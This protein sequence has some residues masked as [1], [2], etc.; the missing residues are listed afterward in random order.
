M[1]QTWKIIATVFKFSWRILNFIRELVFN[2]IFLI[3]CFLV[4]GSI[5]LYQSDSKPD[6]NYF[7]ALYVDLQGIVV[8]QVSTPDP[9]GRMSRE[10]LGTPNNRMQENSLF[11]IV[12]TIR[13]A[14]TDDRITGMVLR[15]D[16]LVSADQPS[17]NFIGKAITEFKESGKPIYAVGDSFSQSQY[18]LASYADHIFLSPQGMV[19]IQGFSTNTLY[20]KSLLEKLKVSSHIFR[21]GTYK[22][23]VEPLMRDN[24]SPEARQATKQWLDA[25]WNN[26]L[27]TLAKT[28]KPLRKVSSLGQ[29]CYLVSYVPPVVITQNTH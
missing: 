9:F 26:Y 7:G 19:G 23:A 14:A 15:L 3:L 22:S 28:A 2:T 5:A 20:Y 21:V 24:M 29:M 8:D 10:L 1:R 11:D 27:D 12:D 18:Y 4:I 13:S 25:L 6:Q 16:N 17:L